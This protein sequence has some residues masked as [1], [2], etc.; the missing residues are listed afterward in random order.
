MPHDIYI[1]FDYSIPDKS[2]TVLNTNIKASYIDD[3]LSE[4]VRSQMGLGPDKQKAAE[5][6]IYNVLIQ[7]DLSYD[8]I[9]VSSN[10]GNKSLTTGI[11]GHSIDNWRFS[12]SM[13]EQIEK[14]EEFVGPPKPKTP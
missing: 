2:A 8:H 9:S 10:A 12:D 13:L 11:I 7:C 14:S 5:R 1:E 4:V 6:D 3:F